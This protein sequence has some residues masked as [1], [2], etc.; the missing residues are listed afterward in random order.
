M[1]LRGKRY[2]PFDICHVSFQG[3]ML[4]IRDACCKFSCETER[5]T[6]RHLEYKFLHI[7]LWA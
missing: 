5:N 7:Y 6:S 4:E 2:V 3:Y 1:S